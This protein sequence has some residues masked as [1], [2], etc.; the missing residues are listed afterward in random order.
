MVMYYS[1]FYFF[2]WVAV[3]DNWG[4]MVKSISCREYIYWE[5][6]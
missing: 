4:I 2:W 3:W 5:F 1:G 6:L